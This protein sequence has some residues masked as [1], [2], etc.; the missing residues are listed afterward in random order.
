VRTDRLQREHGVELRWTVF[1][2]HPETPEEGIDLTDLL[3]RAEEEIEAIQDRLLKLAISEGLPMAKRTRSYNSRLAQELGKWAETQGMPD[4][5][6]AAVFGAFFVKGRNIS[7][8]EE[9]VRIAESV[10]LPADDAREVLESGEFSATVQA[11]WQ[12][13]RDLG[14][15]AVPTHLCGN[16]RLVGFSPYD[17]FL[18]LVGKG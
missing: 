5:Y 8:I 15:T 18:R 16:K 17:D 14:V 4:A 12:R 6:R 13:A 10:G 1:P 3:G 11:D 9:L 2:L 7:Q